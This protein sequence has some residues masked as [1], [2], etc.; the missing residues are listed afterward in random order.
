MTSLAHAASFARAGVWALATLAC[1]VVSP[2][3]LHAELKAGQRDNA[4]SKFDSIVARHWKKKKIEPNPVT[5]D[6]TFVRRVYLDVIGRIPTAEETLAFLDSPAP[7]KRGQLIDALLASEGYVHHFFH[8]WADTLRIWSNHPNIGGVTG[9]AYTRYVKDSLRENKPYDQ[10]VR[11]LLTADSPA[12]ESGAVGY[13]V[14][15]LSMRLDAM[16]ITARIFLGTRIE[17]AQCHDHPFDKWKQLDFYKIAAFTSQIDVAGLAQVGLRQEIERRKKN[18]GGWVDDPHRRVDVLAEVITPFVSNARIVHGDEQLKLPKDYQYANGRP[19]DVILPMPPFGRLPSSAVAGQRRD[20]VFADWMTSRTTPRFTTVIVN[21][22]VRQVFGRS[23][24]EPLDDIRDDTKASIPELEVHLEKLMVAA[25]YDMKAFLGVLLRT[26]AYQAECQAEEPDLEKPYDFNGPVLRRM[27]AEQIWDSCIALIRPDPDAPNDLL[28]QTQQLRIQTAHK[29]S[30]AFEAIEPSA[31]L[32]AID[33]PVFDKRSKGFGKGENPYIDELLYPMLVALAREKGMSQVPTRE[34]LGNNVGKA[35]A[36]FPIPGYDMPK[37]PAEEQAELA[38]RR[39]VWLAAIE[40]YPLSPPERDAFVARLEKLRGT[41]ERAA[42]LTSPA[43]RGHPLRD[44]GQ[45][46]RDLVDN[47]NTE[48]SAAQAL[49]FMNGDIVKEILDHLSPLM[50]RIRSAPT[51]KDRLDAIF[52][53]LYSRRSIARDRFLLG[54]APA[55]ATTPEAIIHAML[56]T[57]Q[58]IFIE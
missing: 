58:F 12:W 8:L 17:C 45:S 41:W 47:G 49:L 43:P 32:N 25:G 4:V 7:D 1:V 31:L 57:H 21:R 54:R 5:K 30:D 27:T 24:V 42:E 18:G 19:G 2:S 13:H 48:A 39:K 29:I 15:D 37:T 56:N 6:S 44:L 51:D 53:S 10:F 34:A 38:A 11:E 50:L 33:A 23:L 28:R 35:M 3:T 36:L 52:L 46:D 20:V 22:L 16:A 55:A 40:R 14:R 9:A 26:R